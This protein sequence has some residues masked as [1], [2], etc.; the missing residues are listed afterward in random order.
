MPALWGR[1][2]DVKRHMAAQRHTTA[3]EQAAR[4]NWR[5]FTSDELCAL[6]FTRHVIATMLARRQLHDRGRGLYV[7]GHPDLSWP[8][9]FLLAQHMA[10]PHSY[11]T[12]GSGLA[13]AGLWR[14]YTREIHL[15]APTRRRARDHVR[16]HFTRELPPPEEMRRDG[17]LR[18]PAVPRL[19]L[20]HAPASTPAQLDRLITKAIQQGRLDHALMRVVIERYPHRPGASAL[21]AAY[22][23]YLPRPGARSELERRFDRERQKRPWIPEPETN[24]IVEAGGIPWEVDRLWREHGVGLEIDGRQYHEAL[25]DRDKDELKRAKLLTL[26]IQTLHVSDWRIEY[27]IADALGDLEAILRRAAGRPACE[28]ARPRA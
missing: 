12:R 18:Y 10:G 25:R 20:E 9:E 13:V 11:L 19:L 4:A 1:A 24:V 7:Y 15:A 2:C 26:G 22:L 5:V 16:I 23:A 8:G 17:P 3:L 21:R 14:P 27:G 6:G 28:P